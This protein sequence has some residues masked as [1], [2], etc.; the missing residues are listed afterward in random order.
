[1][2]SGAHTDLLPTHRRRERRRIIRTINDEF[3][4]LWYID[5]KEDPAAPLCDALHKA[6][7][8]AIA[9]PRRVIL[10]GEVA[11]DFDTSLLVIALAGLSLID[12]VNKR[13]R[14]ELIAK[15]EHQARVFLC[16]RYLGRN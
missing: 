11:A 8:A 7:F 9:L 5:D 14:R 1:M 2:S 15:A 6:G 4:T 10:T 13:I 3:N 12:R 16:W